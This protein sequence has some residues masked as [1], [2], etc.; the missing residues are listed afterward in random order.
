MQLS[1]SGHH[2]LYQ[3][4]CYIHLS[5]TKV[6]SRYLSSRIV[7]VHSEHGLELVR[8]RTTFKPE[9][10]SDLILEINDNFAFL[11]ARRR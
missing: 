5:F 2:R 4:R 7:T 11:E 6:R 8:R 9:E 3:K 1:Q 10:S